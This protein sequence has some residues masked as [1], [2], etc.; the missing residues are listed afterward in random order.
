[1]LVPV[2]VLVEEHKLII[3]AVDAIKR[4]IEEIKANRMVNPNQI[5]TMV[6]F[7]RTYADR[8][9]HGKEEGILFW[10]LSQKE[11]ADVRR[12]VMKELIEEHVFARRTV[13]A[14]EN[15]K[16]NYVSGKTEFLGGLLESLQT[17]VEFYP[18]HIEKE[19]K[20]FFYPTMTYFS[21]QEQED[22]LR[23]F[24]EFNR[25]FTDKRY[26]QIIDSLE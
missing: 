18:I 19:D 11:L 24:Q 3:R 12:Q 22:M 7:F 25:N 26:S 5:N 17:L 2:D 13:T 23:K 20:H 1:M 15:A 8:F 21:S 10:K 9:H 14:L 16:E 4:K 6:D